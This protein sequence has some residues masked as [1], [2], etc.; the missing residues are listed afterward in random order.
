MGAFYETAGAV[1]AALSLGALLWW[2]LGRLLRPIPAPEVKVV[3]TGRDGGETLEQ[4]LRWLH[5]LWGM[6]FLRGTVVIDTTALTEKG[7]ALAAELTKRYPAA[8][9][10]EKKV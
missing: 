8:E 10:H 9:L 3:V 5:W 7:R 4:T 2:L 6:G 1:L